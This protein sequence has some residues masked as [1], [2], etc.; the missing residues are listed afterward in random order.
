MNL[1]VELEEQRERWRSAV[2]LPAPLAGAACRFPDLFIFLA[3]RWYR[4][5]SLYYFLCSYFI[6]F[7]P[8]D[9][10]LLSTTFSSHFSKFSSCIRS[11]ICAVFIFFNVEL[12]PMCPRV[13]CIPFS[14]LLNPKVFSFLISSLTPSSLRS[15]SFTLPEFMYLLEIFLPSVLKFYHI[16]IR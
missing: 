4:H 15:E 8:D 10:F 7:C 13:F 16:M 1:G 12:F 2:S 5:H 11:F 6:N 14:F 3:P 9:H